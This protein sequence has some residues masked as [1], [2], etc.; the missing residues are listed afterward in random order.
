MGGNYE[1]C[2]PKLEHDV[3]MIN[4]MAIY[5]ITNLIAFKTNVLENVLSCKMFTLNYPLLIDHILREAKLYLSTIKHFQS[6]EDMNMEEQMYSQE[7]FWNKIMAEHSKF[8]RGLLD[9]TEDDLINLNHNFANEFDDLTVE[10]LATIDQSYYL[11]SEI[12]SSE[13]LITLFVY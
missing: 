13:S 2:D 9:P 4:E 3:H 12:M 10:V 6:R 7:A 8:I 11:Y 1:T 5:L